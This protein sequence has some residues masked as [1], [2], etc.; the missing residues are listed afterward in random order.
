[1]FLHDFILKGLTDAV[2]KMADYRV[3][4]NAAGWHEK[5]VLTEDDLKTIN[6]L[7]EAKNAPVVDRIPEITDEHIPE[8]IPEIIPEHIIDEQTT[9]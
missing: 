7:I 1:M 3:I 8:I 6:D 4:L 5:G 9:N 2:G